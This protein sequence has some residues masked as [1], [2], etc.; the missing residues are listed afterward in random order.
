Y[1]MTMWTKSQQKGGDIM[2]NT[3]LLEEIIDKSGLKRGKIASE[4]ELSYS[5]LNKKIN[6]Q[7]SFKANEI[8]KLCEVLSITDLRLKDDIFFAE[9][10]D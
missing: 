3:R 4:L 2:T 6:N 10:V 7:V 8:Q 1:T 9:N 5:A